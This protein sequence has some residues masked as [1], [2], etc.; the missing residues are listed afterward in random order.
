MRLTCP[1]KDL[2]KK[3]QGSFIHNNQ[4]LKMTQM[5]KRGKEQTI[6]IHNM[7]ESSKRCAEQKKLDTQEYK[8]V[9]I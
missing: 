9:F 1:Q 6:D 3:V 2:Y 5:S 7:D 8:C 4:K